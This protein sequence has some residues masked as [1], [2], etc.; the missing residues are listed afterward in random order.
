MA[1]RIHGVFFVSG[2]AAL[3]FETLW[4]HQAGL[5]LGNSIWASSA[6]LAGFM[7][8]LA[9]GNLVVARVGER[10]RWPMR[11]Y[12]ALELVIGIGGVSIVFGLPALSPWL[13]PALRPVLELPWLLNVVRFVLALALLLVPA[14][15]M[16]ATLPLL[17]CALHRRDPR[18]GAVLGRLY[19][20]N[21]LGAVVGALLG[22]LW[23]IEWLGIRGAAGVA[24][25]A[26]T[27]AAGAAWTLAPALDAHVE[28]APPAPRSP[29][30]GRGLVL[31]AA[32]FWFGASLLALEVVWFRFLALFE[33]GTTLLFAVMLGVV[34]SGIGAGGLLAAAV[35]GRWPGAHRRLPVLACAAT[36]VALAS[37]TLVQPAV[38][39]E[40]GSVLASVARILGLSAVLIL[41]LSLISGV[42][43]TWLGESLNA[44]SPAEAR[45]AGLLTFS[46][47]VGSALGSLAAAWVLL[48][49]LGVET[50]LRGLA[51]GYAVVGVGLALGPLRPRGPEAGRGRLAVAAAAGLAL[52]ALALL[53]RPPLDARYRAGV[54]RPLEAGLGEVT[55]EIREGLSETAAYTRKEVFGEPLYYRLVTNSHSMSTSTPRGKRYMKL[56]VYLPVAVH[57]APKRALLISYGVGMTAKALTDTRDF[58]RIDMVDISRN[59]LDM[60]RWVFPGS[61]LPTADP[62]V[63]VIVEDGRFFLHTTEERYD[64]ITGEPPPPRNAGIVNLYSE[65]YFRLIRSR[66]NEGG[67]ATYWLPAHSLSHHD[68]KVITAAFCAAFDDC[69]LWGGAGLNWT[70]VGSRNARGPVSREHFERQW[71]DPVV[72][73]ELRALGFERP[74]QLGALFMADGDALRALVDGA[75]PLDDDHPRRLERNVAPDRS[76]ARRWMDTRAAR[77]RFATSETVQRLWPPDLIQESLAN[78]ELQDL[79]NATAANDGSWSPARFEALHRVLT[80]TSLETLPLWLLGSDPHIAAAARDAHHRGGRG[81]ALDFERGLTALAGRD[82]GPAAAR[83]RAA[84]GR[85]A[86]PGR[87]QLLLYA[88][89][90]SGQVDRARA[91]ARN[92][93]FPR[94][95][96]RGDAVAAAFLGR[97]FAWNGDSNGASGL[98]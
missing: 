93:G 1:S 68:W 63:R 29:L 44:E 30:T 46:N 34:L 78:F 94:A 69:S 21:T 50:S 51:A 39:N 59:V 7:G 6:V 92:Q 62:R 60:N 49:A 24:A 79:I 47:T 37:Y 32:A 41:P 36:A 40:T 64:L 9:L 91:V 70:L 65:E 16:G 75:P 89:A 38:S 52:A 2:V 13:V 15:A 28:E 45:S 27:V 11:L 33:S 80:E 19:G 14:S 18:F 72:A 84:Q 73:P 25:F 57:P 5:A 3:L 55:L 10:I 71:R 23:L 56:Y 83:L 66:L 90:M 31:L 35:V 58:E 85:A 61:D 76:E 96:V 77:E 4:F 20:W 86:P 26:N 53:P 43:F 81:A 22:E 67:F 54:L 42:L 98:H 17:V 74:S 97:H 12:A 88:L 48:P 87:L 95:A 82:Y 8:G